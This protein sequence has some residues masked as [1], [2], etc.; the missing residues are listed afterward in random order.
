MAVTLSPFESPPPP[1]LTPARSPMILRK[2]T[3]REN[4]HVHT[5]T[6]ATPGA[7]RGTNQ[8]VRAHGRPVA[9]APSPSPS[10]PPDLTFGPW[11]SV[12]P[13]KRAGEQPPQPILA[14]RHSC[15]S[16]SNPSSSRESP[17]RSQRGDSTSFSPHCENPLRSRLEIRNPDL[18]ERVLHIWKCS[19]AV[20][21]CEEIPVPIPP[22]PQG[23]P[24]A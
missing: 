19:E 4:Q 6:C 14:N 9:P 17:R 8:E 7:P 5:A 11:A 21:A 22:N 12:E 16:P 1:S 18:A 10:P 24:T 13:G 3:A 2:L 20:G 23:R 15:G